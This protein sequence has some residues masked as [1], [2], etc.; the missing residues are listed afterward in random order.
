MI[1][2]EK[3]SAQVLQLEIIA[4]RICMKLNFSGIN[5]AGKL[6]FLDDHS[7]AISHFAKGRSEG[8]GMH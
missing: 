6:W 3:L 5:Q 1:I 2:L 4:V 8:I 7:H